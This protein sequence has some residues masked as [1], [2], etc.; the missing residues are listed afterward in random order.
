MAE[1]RS[2]R[3]Q[4]FRHEEELQSVHQSLEESRGFFR[5]FKRRSLQA[6]ANELVADIH[7]LE[8]VDETKRAEIEAIKAK[9]PPETLGLPE[10]EARVRDEVRAVFA[11]SVTVG[12]DLM[13]FEP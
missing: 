2:L 3:E 9:E 8:G 5:F 13:T 1:V 10:A 11:G 7:A 4:I 6:R 12:A